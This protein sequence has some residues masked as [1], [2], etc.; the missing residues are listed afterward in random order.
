PR[1]CSG[2]SSGSSHEPGGVMSQATGSISRPPTRREVLSDRW[3]RALTR[4]LA[5]A[6]LGLVV[7]LVVQIAI[8]A[9]PA[10][11]D[12]GLRV[13]T[14]WQWDPSGNRYGILPQIGGTLYSSILGVALGSLFGVAVAIFLTQD[15]LPQRL[16]VV[17]KNIIE[18]LAAIPSVVY[19]LWGIFVV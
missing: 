6:V 14:T 19:G 4:G 17:L 16:E 2:S 3:F 5:W 15:Y 1:S 10:V 8:N 18:L 7:F 12:Q 9:G 13:L 11:R